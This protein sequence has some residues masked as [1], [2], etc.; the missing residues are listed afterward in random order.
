MPSTSPLAGGPLA[1]ARVLIVED[2]DDSRE[3]VAEFMRMFGI[4]VQEARSGNE[5]IAKFLEAPASLVVSDIA[6][7]DGDGLSLIRAIRELPSAE[8][9]RLT[10]AIA[11]S[12]GHDSEEAIIAGFNVYLQKP[13]DP[14][15]L[16]EVMRNFLEPVSCEGSAR[17]TWS[18]QAHRPGLVVSTFTG[19]VTA[20]DAQLAIEALVLHLERGPMDVVIDLR[21]IGSFDPSATIRG[22]RV[23]WNLRRRIR[24]VVLVGGPPAARLVSFAAARLMGVPTRLADEMPEL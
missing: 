16:V 2:T 13:V 18:V 9:G 19:H 5:A 11:V 3:M 14:V 24:S 20:A 4:D 15:R 23:A 1:G 17:A 22:Q 6:M 8:Q 7:P 10:P 21:C 12:A